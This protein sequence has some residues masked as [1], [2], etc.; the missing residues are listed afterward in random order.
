MA[1]SQ[2]K[3][4]LAGAM[5][6]PILMAILTAWS[7]VALAA[8]LYVGCPAVVGNT[9][10]IGLRVHTAPG[11]SPPT[12]ATY[13]D[14]TLVTIVGGPQWCDGFQWWQHARNGLVGW[15]AADWL[16]PLACPALPGQPTGLAAARKDNG[17]TP[18]VFL[19]WSGSSGATSYSL[20]RDGS[21]LISVDASWTTFWNYG[22]LTPGQTYRY[23]V[24]AVN[25]AGASSASSTVSYTVP[26]AVPAL[27]GQPT[28][29]TATRQ[30]NGST[31]G[32]LLTWTA[33]TG[34]TGYYFYRDGIGMCLGAQTT[35]WNYGSLTPGQTYRYY[36]VA[37]NSAGAS[38]ASNTVSYTVPAATPALPGQPTGLTATRK[39]NGST[40]G[41]FLS[42]SGSSG[43]ASYQVYRGGSRIASVTAPSTSCWDYSG[44]R[45]NT[46]YVYYVVAVNS[47]G[48]SSS[49]TTVS[50]T[51][52]AAT[53][54][55]PGQ[56]TGLM[57]TRKDNG[58]TPGV[59]LSWSGSTGAVSYEVYRGGSRVA[60][61]TAPSISHWDFSGLRANTT[62]VYYVV[63]VNSAGSSSPSTTVSYTVPA[64]TPALP[65]QPTGLTVARKDS[66]STPGVF[67]SWSGS[68]GAASY[69]VYR[70]GSRIASVTAPSTSYWD[71]SGLRANTT[72]VYYV[73]AV[74]ST[75][76]NSPS[77]TVSYTVPA[78]ALPGQ[79]IG[80]AARQQDRSTTP[81]VFLSWSGS[82]GAASYEI[83]RSGSRVASVASPSTSY[84]D[85]GSL[86]VGQTYIY[87]VKARNSAGVGPA[88]GTMSFTPDALPRVIT[89][90]GGAARKYWVDDK[91]FVSGDV[92]EMESNSPGY[93]FRRGF[94]PLEELVQA[95]HGTVSAA[96]GGG[97]RLETGGKTYTW[98]A[99]DRNGA[100]VS[101]SS[102]IAGQLGYHFFYTDTG[103]NPSSGAQPV[104]QIV[105]TRQD[106]LQT[107]DVV[108]LWARSQAGSMGWYEYCLRFIRDSFAVAGLTIPTDK[109]GRDAAVALAEYY[110]SNAQA[111]GVVFHHRSEGGHPPVGTI[112]FY[113]PL[114]TASSNYW[115]GHI[116]ISLGL[117]VTS[118]QSQIVHAY[119]S[120][121]VTDRFFDGVRKLDSNYDYI[122][123][124]KRNGTQGET[125]VTCTGADDV[126]LGWV[127]PTG[128]R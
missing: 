27:P 43:A 111:L 68:T 19:S 5:V 51:V 93:S 119:G 2:V 9:G 38:S 8:D 128:R 11:L 22:S 3:N 125:W 28:G 65:G 48:D 123:L 7:P 72:Y 20:Y 110:H 106:Q 97:V 86:R 80:L 30:D 112:V 4:M 10:A 92:S 36:V 90:Q 95:L 64:A 33:G 57:A 69:Q 113:G 41:V 75:G 21:Y 88:S 120:V 53:P 39:D 102:V 114:G 46:T 37:V 71:H 26:A 24:V 73:V 45:A 29:L 50:Y 96:S 74:N 126:Y 63:A 109:I 82:T 54:A 77:T 116:A 47:A 124:K 108:A 78:P 44:L 60:S 99:S 14:G 122:G 100:R 1:R 87:F 84:W 61:V 32:V 16:Y 105:L 62:Y 40:P 35:Y 15:S 117:D 89:F 101:L 49:S 83:Y 18:G 79:P 52:P 56:P 34:A 17:S 55:L 76:S 81:G 85:C 104:R 118:G 12:I 59:F 94:V 107:V 23:Y 67:L 70:G 13:F 91:G 66:G 6:L 98:A 25:S 31:P 103:A 127:D 58:S 115:Q 42:W 121:K